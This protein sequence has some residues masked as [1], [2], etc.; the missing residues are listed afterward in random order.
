[1]DKVFEL[2]GRP[3]DRHL[4][5]GLADWQLLIMCN[6]YVVSACVVCRI[7]RCTSLLSLYTDRLKPGVPARNNGANSPS[8]KFMMWRTCNRHTTNRPTHLIL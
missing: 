5:I 3:T 4:K 6:I 8:Y 2:I 1:M 7:I